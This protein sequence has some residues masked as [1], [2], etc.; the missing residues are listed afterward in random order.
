MKLVILALLLFGCAAQEAHYKLIKLPSG[1]QVKVLSVGKMY[2]GQGDPALLLK[3]ETDLPIGDIPALQREADEIWQSFK[4]DVENAHLSN[5]IISATSHPTPGFIS[6]SQ[7]YN[8][9]FQ[10]SADGTW[11]RMPNK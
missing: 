3:Y 4:E 10:K 11:H 8:F 9:V 7:S 1:K 6:R 5:G 2:F